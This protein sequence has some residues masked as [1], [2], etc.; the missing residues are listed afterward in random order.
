MQEELSY[1]S[2]IDQDE[3]NADILES[4][5]GTDFGILVES[6]DKILSFKGVSYIPE[7]QSGQKLVQ[8]K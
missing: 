1:C 5:Y 6:K 7:I 4:C 8:A 2:D 3:M